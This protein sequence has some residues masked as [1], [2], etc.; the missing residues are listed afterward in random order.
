MAYIKSIF[1][2]S[3]EEQDTQNEQQAA[4]GEKLDDMAQTDTAQQ[5]RKTEAANRIRQKLGNYTYNPFLKKDGSLVNP[6]LPYQQM[7][8]NTLSTSVARDWITAATGLT[9][10][11]SSNTETETAEVTEDTETEID[12]GNVSGLTATQLAKMDIASELPK[13]SEAQIAK[14]ISSHFGN[15][16]VISESDAAGIK[17]AQDKTGMS[18]LAILGIG[19]LESGYGTSQIANNTGNLWGYGAT[20]IN[21]EGNAHKYGEVSSGAAQYATEFMKDY[22]NGYGAKSIYSAGS[23]DNPAGKGYA[24]YDNGTINSGWVNNVSSIMETFCSTLTSSGLGSS[25]RSAKSSSSKGKKLVNTAKKYLGTKYVWGGTSPSGFDCSGLIQYVL[26]ENGIDISRTTYDQVNEGK[27]VSK[28]QLQ[29]GDIVF[30][31]GSGGSA[32][33]PGHVGMY[34]G[35]GQYLHAPSTGD[36]VKISNLNSRSDYVCARRMT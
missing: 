8:D 12:G 21:P 6:Y 23:G 31:K 3:E 30:F 11:E 27:A 24:Y 33:A 1:G 17:A 14:I 15:S 16:S 9:A 13:L 28:S 19:A 4:A 32:S 35:N 5:R 7:L 10:T 25:G 18:A 26:A 20:N 36:V 2:S 22:Y 34:I 29:P